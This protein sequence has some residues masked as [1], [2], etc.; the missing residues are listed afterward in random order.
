M[1]KKIVFLDI[2]GTLSLM[3]GTILESSIYA[4]TKARANGHKIYLCTGRSRPEVFGDIWDI[5]FDGL[6]GAGGAYIEV[7]N[8]VL[9]YRKLSLKQCQQA[10]DFFNE[11]E[12]DFFLECNSGIYTSKN[13]LP[14]IEE[15]VYG[16]ISEAQ[17]N[18]IKQ[19]NEYHPFLA[20]MISGETNLY[21]DDV[22]KISFLGSNRTDFSEISAKFKNEFSIIH[23]S[24]DLFGRNSGELGALGINKG[25]AIKMLL[26]HIGGSIDNCYA[27][28][29]GINDLQMFECCAKSVAMGNAHPEI[30]AIADF[31]TSSNE[32]NG[33]YEAFEYLGLLD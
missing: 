8:Q 10:V 28:G 7:D 19:R 29:D 4:C 27:I 12:I 17:L 32:E 15:I 33:V 3:D 21:R 20:L 9:L 14:V 25:S 30:K 1:G 5:G 18:E 31:V 13:F 6:I 16:D 11:K 26:E 2:D 23:G 24:V 22:N